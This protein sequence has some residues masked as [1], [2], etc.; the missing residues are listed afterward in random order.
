MIRDQIVFG[1]ADDQL[2]ERLLREDSLSLESAIKAAQSTEIAANQKRVWQSP[3]RKAVEA[4]SKEKVSSK[5]K[6]PNQKRACYKCK[7]WHEPKKCPA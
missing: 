3:E 1:T 7:R 6:T 5:D 2:R 4:I